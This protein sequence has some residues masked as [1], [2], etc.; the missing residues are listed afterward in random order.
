MANKIEWFQQNRVIE[1]ISRALK[2]TCSPFI[3]VAVRIESRY[4]HWSVNCAFLEISACPNLSHFSKLT[5]RA[6]ASEQSNSINSWSIEAIVS[7]LTAPNADVQL[8]VI[9]ILDEI[10]E[11][12]IHQIGN[13]AFEHHFSSTVCTALALFHRTCVCNVVHRHSLQ[14]STL[15]LSYLFGKYT[16][17]SSISG[18]PACCWLDANRLPCLPKELLFK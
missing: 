13:D 3:G 18:M 4:I 11:K 14:P 7:L 1:S 9:Q 6:H 17:H 15:T 12:A 16:K 8:L 10:A 2:V 5:A